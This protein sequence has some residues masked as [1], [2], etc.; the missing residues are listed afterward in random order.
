MI[1]GQRRKWQFFFRSETEYCGLL[2]TTA[3]LFLI[4]FLPVVLLIIDYTPYKIL[5]FLL[6]LES[7]YLR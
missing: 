5:I 2:A 7:Y 4:D 1:S 6:V 3:S